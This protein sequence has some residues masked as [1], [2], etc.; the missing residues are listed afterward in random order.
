MARSHILH[1]CVIGMESHGKLTAR[2][3]SSLADRLS[4]EALGKHVRGNAT[5][6]FNDEDH[7]MEINVASRYNKMFY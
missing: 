5:R 6:L 3:S 4:G 1:D 7:L 2:A